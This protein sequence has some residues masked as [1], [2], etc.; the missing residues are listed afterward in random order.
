[1]SVARPMLEAPQI[2]LSRLIWGNGNSLDRT[3]LVLPTIYASSRRT[4]RGSCCAAAEARCINYGNGACLFLGESG[5][6][7]SVKRRSIWLQ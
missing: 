3:L 1:M 5:D 4:P 7:I 6:S 2:L